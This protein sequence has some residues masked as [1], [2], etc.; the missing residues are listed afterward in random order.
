VFRQRFVLS[1]T[2]VPPAKLLAPAG[3]LALRSFLAIVNR[4]RLRDEAALLLFNSVHV[5]VRADEMIE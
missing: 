5:A 4:P 3:Q 2:S 1:V